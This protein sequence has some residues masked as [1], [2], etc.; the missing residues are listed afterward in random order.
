MTPP[1]RAWH[2]GNAR[3][4]GTARRGWIV[5]HFMPED[6]LRRS[7]DVEVKWG[8]HP[9]GDERETPQATE[10]RTT[11]VVL[12]SGRF[13]LS[14]DDTSVTLAEPGDYAMWGPGTGHSWRA[15]QDSVVLTLRWPSKP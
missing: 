9:A 5:G 4:D 2:V 7:E 13:E 1:G 15:A 14:L 3:E 8:I 11:L 6:D 10:H 12:V